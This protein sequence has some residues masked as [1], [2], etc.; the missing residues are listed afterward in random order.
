MSNQ[1]FRLFSVP[2]GSSGQGFSR[3]MSMP[4]TNVRIPGVMPASLAAEIS[5][6][7]IELF[8]LQNPSELEQLAGVSDLAQLSRGVWQWDF[9]QCMY[10]GGGLAWDYTKDPNA[11]AWAADLSTM[12]GGLKG[13]FS[14]PK[15]V[16]IPPNSFF[17]LA[18]QFP[19]SVRLSRDAMIRMTIF[20]RFKPFLDFHQEIDLPPETDL[21]S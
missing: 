12:P 4:E 7:S 8:S 1:I 17:N 19:D 14:Y 15:P 18:V 10:P 16:L 9:V 13:I 5:E 20:C 3:P 6:V 21:L 2:C 11:K